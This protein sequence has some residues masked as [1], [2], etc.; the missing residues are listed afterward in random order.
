MALAQGEPAEAADMNQPPAALQ[1]QA[2]MQ[3]DASYTPPQMPLQLPQMPAA[4]S[5]ATAPACVPEPKAKKAAKAATK[6]E[7]KP[8]KPYMPRGGSVASNPQLRS[9]G[10]FDCPGQGVLRK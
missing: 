6:K 9:R 1:T 2:P 3:A 7:V 10:N 5:S 4:P 8:K